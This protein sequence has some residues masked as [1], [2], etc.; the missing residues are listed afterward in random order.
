MFA[1]T[2]FYAHAQN[3]ILKSLYLTDTAALSSGGAS[4]IR[5]YSG[6]ATGDR[7]R[8]AIGTVAPET[9]SNLGSSFRLFRYAD[10]GALLGTVIAIDRNTGRVDAPLGF[11]AGTLQANQS[12]ASDQ[13]GYGAGIF[14]TGTGSNNQSVLGFYESNGSVRQGYVGK[15]FATST[16]A[17]IYLVSEIGGVAL[18]PKNGYVNLVNGTSNIIKFNTVGYGAPTINTRSLGSKIVLHDAVA[19]GSSNA[20]YAIGLESGTATY[21]WFGVPTNSTS[22]GWNFYGGTTKV[23]NLDGAG[24]LN[25]A[26]NVFFG[27]TSTQVTLKVNGTINARVMTV[28]TTGWPDYV[29]GKDYKLPSLQEV[30]A[31]IKEHQHLPNMPAAAEL[32]KNGLDVGEMQ[33]KMMEKIEELTLHL[34]RLDEENRQLKAE[35]E[36]MKSSK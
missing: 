2:S 12:V 27:T 1:L 36:K 9:G 29:F 15:G 30:S 3:N 14:G 6:A 25:L 11:R 33:K 20:D 13:P 26:G 23:G 19:S 32:E 10:N 18:G 35:V 28:V 4:Y 24:N 21:G 7:L 34:I 16:N 17:D 8:W 22:H 5:L 31:Y